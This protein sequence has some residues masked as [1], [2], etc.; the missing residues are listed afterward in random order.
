MWLMEW[1]LSRLGKH[2]NRC[3]EFP[4]SSRAAREAVP[5]VSVLPFTHRVVCLCL[6]KGFLNY[7]FF[8]MFTSKPI[9]P[10]RPAST[11]LLVCKQPG[12]CREHTKN[13][14][15]TTDSWSFVNFPLNG[16]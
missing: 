13:S 9:L 2:H 14:L 6:Q 3:R 12:C 1:P 8:S 5:T 7:Y 4:V 11:A 15:A 16:A 10:T